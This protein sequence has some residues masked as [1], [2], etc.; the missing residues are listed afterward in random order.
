MS[1]SEYALR[2]MRKC[3]NMYLADTNRYGIGVFA[4]KPFRAGEIVLRDDDGDYCDRVCSYRELC[5]RGYDLEHM[6]QVGYD[7]F[8][9][10]TG[11]I[12]DF[13][14]HSCDPNIGIRLKANGQIILALR[15]IAPHE[16][17]TYDFSTYQNNPHERMRCL[18]GAPNCRGMIGNFSS[19]PLALQRRYR[20]LGVVGDF[21]VSDVRQGDRQL[22]VPMSPP[23]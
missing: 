1:S 15:D 8:R 7:Q 4:A 23:P 14:N 17:L 10:P 11:S 21:V 3:L 9:L 13:F 20:A 5:E 18:C 2:K 22:S 12:E 6:M 16:E 19:L